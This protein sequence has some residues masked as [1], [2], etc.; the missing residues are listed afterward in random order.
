MENL[1]RFTFSLV[2]SFFLLSAFASADDFFLGKPA[3]DEQAAADCSEDENGCKSKWKSSVEFGYVAVSGNTDTTS[4][5][6]RF[7]LGYEVE[8]WRHG[9][10]IASQTTTTED[11]L[12]GV[13]TDAE[14]YTAQVK[15]DYKYSD[16]AYAFGIAD[17]DNTKDSGFDYQISYALGAGYRFIEQ[18]AH[19]LDAEMGIGVRDSKT[20][21]TSESNSESIVRLAGLYKWQISK[22]STF[23]QQ[24]STE[25]GDDNTIS[26]T[27]TGVTANIIESL[28]LKVSYTAKRQTEVP[29]GNEKLETITSFTVVYTF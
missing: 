16:S 29:V 21:L 11:R 24:L 20:E 6:G 18:K 4:V 22:N 9:G 3:E 13:Q 1:S 5:N 15:S 19:Q 8:K 28:A 7:E 23:E 10:F 25:V 2:I 27:Y 17:Y 12:T 26:R 14:K